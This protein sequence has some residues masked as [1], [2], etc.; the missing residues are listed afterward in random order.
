MPK[1]TGFAPVPIRGPKALPFIGV[2]VNA[3][4]LAADPIGRSLELRKRGEVVAV[5]DRSP[6]LVMAFGA[7]RNRE[8]LSSTATFENDGEFVVK[9]APGSPL[10]QLSRGLTFQTGERHKRHR[11]LMMPAFHKAALDG[12]APAIVAVAEGA[13]A[14][15]PVGQI[16]DVATLTRELVQYIALRCLFGLDWTTGDRGLGRMAANAV[17]L[18]TSP[19]AVALPFRIPGTPYARLM[20]VAEELVT[21]M[22]ALIEEKRQHL[23]GANDALA[24]IL[25]ASEND[26]APLGDDELVGEATTL[27]IA[28]HDTQARTLAWTLFLLG[29]HPNVLADVLDEI[30][31]VL[32]G[33]PPEVSHLPKLVLV[34]R[35]L[36]ETMRVLAPVPVSFLKVAQTE[37]RLGG[38]TLPRGAN[39]VLSPFITHRDPD[40]Y[41]EPAR[42][43]PERWERLSPTLYEYLPFGA[44]PRM[45]IGAGFA[46]LA[47]RVVLPMILQRYRTTLAFGARVS[48]RV[49]ANILAPRY[50]LPMLIAPQDRQ[51]AR[52][53]NVRGDIPEIVDLS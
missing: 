20:T 42:F 4:R 39:V 52:C 22:R 5:T 46:T 41:S 32:R 10:E 31:N 6:A 16:A 51:F 30:D 48:R 3:V 7:E 43:R 50:G 17:E 13:L 38:H 21:L 37:V 14:K 11:R 29:Q 35:V 36:K 19:L 26:E 2:L 47:M 45:C 15:W 34:D 23:A 25:R 9:T 44:G 27:Y 24:L 53:E 8:V 12:Y 18:I 49:R 40:M 33:G 1:L 28:G